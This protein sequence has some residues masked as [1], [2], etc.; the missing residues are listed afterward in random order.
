MQ[1]NIVKPVLFIANSEK[2]GPKSLTAWSPSAQYRWYFGT[3]F[4]IIMVHK[5][6][7]LTSFEHDILS[8]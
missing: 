1:Q 6:N 4:F 5:E 3:S 7:M 8:V 2:N